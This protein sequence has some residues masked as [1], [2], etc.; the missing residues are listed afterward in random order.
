MLWDE[1]LN[2]EMAKAMLAEGVLVIPLRFFII[3]IISTMHTHQ[4]MMHTLIKT[5]SPNSFPVVAK[6]KARIRV[7]ISAAHSDQVNSYRTHCNINIMSRRLTLPLLPLSKSVV[8]LELSA[9]TLATPASLLL[10]GIVS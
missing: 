9:R 7:Q 5:P 4:N 8:S 6:G 1:Q 10:V 2:Q 3:I